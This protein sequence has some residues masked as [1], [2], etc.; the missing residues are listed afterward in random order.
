MSLATLAECPKAS[1]THACDEVTAR[2]HARAIP[3]LV[4]RQSSSSKIETSKMAAATNWYMQ[5]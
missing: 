2:A 3:V 1:R 5:P 4:H